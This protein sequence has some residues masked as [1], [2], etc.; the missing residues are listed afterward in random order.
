MMDSSREVPW[1]AAEVLELSPDDEIDADTLAELYEETC[2]RFCWPATPP[3]EDVASL[4][5]LAER[6]A[7]AKDDPMAARN[8]TRYHPDHDDSLFVR[9][10][11][12]GKNSRIKQVW[13]LLAA[14]R[15]PM[16]MKNSY[17][18]NNDKA[19][20]RYARRNPS[21]AEQQRG[22]TA[23]VY[24][25]REVMQWMLVE[26]DTLREES[27]KKFKLTP[28]G[29][30]WRD[31]KALLTVAIVHHRNHDPEDCRDE[32]LEL[33]SGQENRLQAKDAPGAG[34]FV[35]VHRVSVRGANGKNR[36]VY[37]AEVRRRRGAWRS[38]TTRLEGHYATAELALLARALWLLAH[39]AYLPD[40]YTPTAAEAQVWASAKA[41]ASGDTVC[42]RFG[43]LRELPREIQKYAQFAA[44]QVRK[45]RHATVQTR[46]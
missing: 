12:T 2:W 35:G 31:A 32:N 45:G 22:K 17:N 16:F 30:K 28:S 20:G 4:A 46:C 37:R 19:G 8:M 15:Y 39:P 40:R 7:M 10:L 11:L 36:W 42:A 13:V 34:G 23:T 43:L 6:E 3:D 38:Q 5:E 41:L 24:L 26:N 27:L 21:K 14:Q 44:I 9:C 25:H 29:C 18:V 1:H 33:V